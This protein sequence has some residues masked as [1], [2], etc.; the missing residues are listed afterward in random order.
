MFRRK[1]DTKAG[2]TI[3]MDILTWSER[4][5]NGEKYSCI[6]IDDTSNFIW[7][8][9]Q[10]KKSDFCDEFIKFIKDKRK[11]PEYGRRDLFLVIRLDNA[12]EW[13]RWFEGFHDKCKE[14][15]DPVPYFD[16][17]GTMVDSRYNGKAE[18]TAHQEA[19]ARWKQEDDEEM[20]NTTKE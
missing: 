1:L 16:Y 5:E 11:D 7:N 10:I 12:G 4:G 3:N 20:M 6:L 17:Q 8:I 2:R 14:E 9:E 15:L 19:Q 13:G 18:T